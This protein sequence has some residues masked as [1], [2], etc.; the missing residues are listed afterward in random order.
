MRWTDAE[1]AALLEHV[2]QYGTGDWARCAEAVGG[3]R[4]DNAVANRW[5]RDLKETDRGRA[6]LRL[7]SSQPCTGG[8]SILGD[9]YAALTEEG[10]EEEEEE[11]ELTAEEVERAVAAAEEEVAA[12]EAIKHVHVTMTMRSY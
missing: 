11:E 1:D 8:T 9:S 3:G 7:A 5:H 2:A 4:T 12:A 6:A 10:E